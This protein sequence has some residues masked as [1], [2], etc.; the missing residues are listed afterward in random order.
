MILLRKFL[1]INYDELMLENT[2]APEKS[3]TI[4][5]YLRFYFHVTIII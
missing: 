1:E 3:F 4:K 2:N 5:W